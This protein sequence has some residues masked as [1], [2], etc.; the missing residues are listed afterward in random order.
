MVILLRLLALA[1]ILVLLGAL[2]L[3][4]LLLTRGIQQQPLVQSTPSPRQE[5]VARIK[6][7]VQAHNP[8][9]LQDGEVRTFSVTAQDVNIG[10]RSLLPMA[11]RQFARVTFSDRLGTLDY[12]LRLPDSLPGAYPNLSLS[13]NEHEQRPAVASL[14]LGD[15]TLPGW[16]IRPLV[17]I[18]DHLLQASFTEYNDLHDTMQSMTIEDGSVNVTYRWDRA[19][20]EQLAQRGREVFVSAEDRE[21]MLAYYR[22]LAARSREV[23][24]DAS[25]SKL[26]QPLFAT[27]AQR[28]SAASAGAENRALLLVVGTVLNRS[29]IHRLLGGDADDLNPQHYPVRWTLHGRGDLAQHFAISAAIAAAGGDALADAIGV[30]KELDDSRGGSGFSFPDLLADRAGVELSNAA[31]GDR[32]QRLQA[33]MAITPLPEHSF[34]PSFDKLPEGLMEM[35][36]KQRYS[37]LDDVRY[38]VVKSEIDRRIR[39]LPV[40]SL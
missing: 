38:R 16:S 36:F 2:S 35:D 27:A 23:G 13:I 25:L 19:L 10:L 26:L 33:A 4:V 39:Q 37:D 18:V 7:L 3:P 29:P 12:T 21:R 20:V 6:A 9:R 32:A 17:A 40:H 14:Q 11:D 31:L 1:T 28:S 30:M 15:I 34:M 24:R 5:D 8:R 22:V